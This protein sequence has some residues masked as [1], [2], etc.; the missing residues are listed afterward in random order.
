MT[1]T[2]IAIA[3][4]DLLPQRL[5]IEAVY[6][7]QSVARENDWDA[8]IIPM[9]DFPL[10]NSENLPF[11]GLIGRI[12]SKLAQRA[13]KLNIPAV[14]IWLN[15]DA[16]GLPGVFPD[17]RQVCRV[18]VEHLR[19]IGFRNLAYV[20]FRDDLSVTMHIEG[21]NSVT[22]GHPSTQVDLVDRGFHSPDAWHAYTRAIRSIV[23][24]WT[25]PVG[26]CVCNDFVSRLI[27][28]TCNDL[29]YRVPNEVAI[30]SMGNEPLV[31]EMSKPTL[32]SIDVG[33]MQVGVYAARHLEAMLNSADAGSGTRF[34]PPG[35]LVQ[36]QSTDYLAVDDPIVKACM[37]F[38]AENV[39]RPIS[40]IEIAAHACVSRRTLERRFRESVG[41][42]IG[43][44]I[45][46]RRVEAARKQLLDPAA[47]VKR[48][49]HATGFNS[50]SHFSEVF[51][52]D[53][54]MSPSQYRLLHRPKS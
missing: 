16:K 29:G 42:S 12:G 48:V 46:R 37:E 44:E 47:S 38:I 20:G 28:D 35:A 43:E 14:N 2:R 19:S 25:L 32:T 3:I 9:T 51:R 6:G 11:Q 50:S 18:G 36:R 40:A 26:V 34:L 30:V 10:A 8:S 39:F 5:L 49:A 54:G 24:S 22:H 45:R 53:V 27:T 52:Q 41:L 23:E 7:I 1:K 33:Y 15:S 21:L 4:D 17:W 13:K 31:C